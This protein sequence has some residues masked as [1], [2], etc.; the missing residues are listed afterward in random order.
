[1]RFSVWIGLQILL[2]WFE[3]DHFY[4][5]SQPKAFIHSQVGDITHRKIE[6]S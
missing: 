3:Y 6:F 1:M 5:A 4:L 2:D